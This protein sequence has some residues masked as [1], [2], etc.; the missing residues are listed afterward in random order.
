[1]RKFDAA[2]GAV[3]DD[4]R[5]NGVLMERHEREPGRWR[6]E[7]VTLPLVAPV[8]ELQSGEATYPVQ[9]SPFSALLSDEE[10]QRAGFG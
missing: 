2:T 5:V 1:M 7:M 9:H 8:R 10:R 3:I 4:K 6:A